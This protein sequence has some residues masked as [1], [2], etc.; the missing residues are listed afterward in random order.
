MK[1]IVASV[2]LVALGASA[3]QSVSGQGLESAAPAKPWNV[4][5][6]LNAFY[7]S[8]PGT[9]GGGGQPATF[10]Y[11][12]SPAAALAWSLEQTSISL[13]F[14]YSLKYYDHTPPGSTD[15]IDQDFTFNL[16]LTHAFSERYRGSVRD[17]FVIGQEPDMLRAGSLFS[18]YQRVSGDN[19]RNTAA[20]S[21]DGELTRELGFE[22][23]YD[24]NY[25]N[26]VDSGGNAFSPSL[27]GTLNRLENY[28]HLDG[29][30][31]LAPETTAIL[32]YQYA[33]TDYTGDEQIGFVENP[34]LT[35]FTPYY[36]D[37]RNSRSHYGYV[38]LDH[39]FTTGLTGGLRVG[40]R[41][42]DFYNDPYNTSGDVTPYVSLS[43]RYTYARESYAE[44]GAK[45]DRN[46]TDVAG[47]FQAG[48]N[49][50]TTDETSGTVYGSVNHHFTPKLVGSLTAQ[51]QDS[52]FNGG[53]EDGQHELYYLAGLNLEYR[54]DSHL[55]ANIG[56][57]YDKLDS[58]IGRS[59]DRH[60][61]YLG[62]T[63]SY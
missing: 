20:L 45:Y 56:Y 27:A 35:T 12:I 32:G 51:I 63:A 37:T 47:Q 14:L 15:R 41:Y 60:R 57:N 40:A 26:Y 24:N 61:V 22:V 38:G 50:L 44:L 33:Q 46:A 28:L 43:L 36:S 49:S 13:D 53:G 59:F 42:I 62:I 34:S 1:K 8:N 4:S 25:Y 5:A 39:T 3:V 16:A 19:I 58:D 54:F 17:G 31:K 30:W 48:V 2:G 7:D 11:E 9:V 55:S 52:T 10:G 6:S 18:T 23:G 21:F 29:R